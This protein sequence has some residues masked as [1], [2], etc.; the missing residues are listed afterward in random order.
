MLMMLIIGNCGE[1]FSSA[2]IFFRENDGTLPQKPILFVQFQTLNHIDGL[3]SFLR[4][5]LISRF[6]LFDI[7]R[8][9]IVTRVQISFGLVR[10]F[11]SCLKLSQFLRNCCLLPSMLITFQNRVLF[12]TIRILCFAISVTLVVVVV[13][14]LV[15]VC[16]VT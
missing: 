11:L 13:V 5:I 3:K 15:I 12:A 1:N 10:Q 6:L 4:T 8:G 2:T 14:Y 16:F 9:N 7:R